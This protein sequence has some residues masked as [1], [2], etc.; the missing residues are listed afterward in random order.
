M[1]KESKPETYVET[2]KARQRVVS[3]LNSHIQSALGRYKFNLIPTGDAQSTQYLTTFESTGKNPQIILKPKSGHFPSRLNELAMQM[4]TPAGNSTN[5]TLYYDFGNGFHKQ[6]SLDISFQNDRQAIIRI[7]LPK[8][9]K[10]I[11]LDPCDCPGEILMPKF[12][13]RKISKFEILRD[14]IRSRNVH[15]LKDLLTMTKNGL[16]IL[17]AQGLS[18]IKERLKVKAEENYSTWIAMY[19][20]LDSATIEKARKTILNFQ[21]KPLISIIMPVYNTPEL[22]LRETLDSVTEQLYANWE[23]CIVDDHSSDPH[24]RLILEEYGKKI[25]QIHVRYRDVNGHI[26]LA[27]NDALKMA[28]GEFIVFMDH[29]DLLSP[30]ALYYVVN[31]LNKN[32][33]LDFLYSDEDKIDESGK[34]YD[35]Y[36][37]PDWNPHLF[38][39]QNYLNHLTAARKSLVMD[40]DGFRQ[41]LEGSQDWD[42]YMRLIEKIDPVKICHIPYVLYHWR[43]STG[44]TALSAEEKPYIMDAQEKVLLDHFERIGQKVILQKLASG[45]WFPHFPCP[46]PLPLVSIIIPTKDKVNLLE[47]CIQSIQSKTS[48]PNYEILVVDNLSQEKSSINYLQTLRN[49]TR[50]RVIEYSNPFNFSAINNFAVNQSNGSVVLLLNNDTE[51]I[52]EN[53]LEQLVSY[54]SIPDIGAVGTMLYYPDNNIQHAGVILGIGGVAGHAYL[55]SP[56]GSNG[57]FGRLNLVQNLSSVT[58][59]CLAIEKRKYLEVGGLNEQDLKIAFN[60]VDFCIK[61]L[62]KGYRNLWTPHVELYHYESAS[63][64]YE[65]TPDKKKRFEAEVLYMLKK[66]EGILDFDPA[67]NPNLSLQHSNFRTPCKPR[68]K[69]L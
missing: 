10:A 52:T 6:D 31:E 26:S 23:L 50:I 22:I 64:G 11:R 9:I 46:D 66:W 53:W 67:Y 36:F 24:V 7:N 68:V 27:S 2:Q 20:T 34:R 1:K 5:F 29:D 4:K 63:R 15:S 48:Y 41:G 33:E 59:A 12:E 55:G 54:A 43:A 21:Y 44:S 14:V 42:L 19:D 30:T 69:T 56:R 61:L 60:D 45:Y 28:N 57:Q 13:I 32:P 25:P 17:R 47:R 40:V 38:L 16:R 62:Q 8:N 51:V 58:A 39:G 3:F 49:S 18:G 65:D 37:K 35:P